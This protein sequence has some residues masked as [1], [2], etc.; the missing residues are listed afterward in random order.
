MLR[1]ML[2]P[3]D[4]GVASVRLL[5]RAAR[6]PLAPD[7]DVALLHAVPSLLVGGERGRAEADARALLDEHASRLVSALPEHATVRPIVAVGSAARAIAD[8][9]RDLAADVV[10]MGR[11]HGA[12]R[13]VVLGS[14]AERVLRRAGA[15]VLVVRL[16]AGGPYAKPLLALDDGEPVRDLLDALFRVLPARRP[17]IEWVHACAAPF[18]G[19]V[20]PSFTNDE[21]RE[22]RAHYHEKA[23]RGI[24]AGVEAATIAL[25]L[26]PGAV[27]CIGHVAHGPP[28]VVVPDLVLR[29][30]TDLL[31][32]GTHAYAPLARAFLGTVAGDLLREVRC[33]VLVV[34]PGAPRAEGA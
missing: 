7:V 4:L 2:I 28:R 14:T 34:P 27:S 23:M 21:A 31:V 5:E 9:A 8:H 33:D 15:P 6:L 32:L 18:E 30:G 1:S 22:Y 20:Y 25:A 24:A 10:V 13:D 3:L 26:S 17:A 11:G 12:V 19:I 29:R 16:P